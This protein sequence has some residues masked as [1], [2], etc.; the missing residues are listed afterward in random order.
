MAFFADSMDLKKYAEWINFFFKYKR[1][2]YRHLNFT[3]GQRSNYSSV[4]TFK[5]CQN[6]DFEIEAILTSFPYI[7]PF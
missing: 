7:N 3:H 2:F 5:Y 6:C 1:K 4:R